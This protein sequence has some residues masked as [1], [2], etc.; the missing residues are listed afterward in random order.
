MQTSLLR[1][2]AIGN[3]VKVKTLLARG[4]NANLASEDDRLTPLMWAA[5]NGHPGAVKSLLDKGADPN[6][7][8]NQG[9]TALMLAAEHGHA[10][11]VKLL[12]EHGADAHARD[13]SGSTALGV[14]V[15]NDHKRIVKLL[16]DAGVVMA[17]WMDWNARPRTRGQVLGPG[18]QPRLPK[19]AS[20]L[21][22]LRTDEPPVEPEKKTSISRPPQP[23]TP[24]PPPPGPAPKIDFSGEAPLGEAK[25]PPSIPPQ[26][27]VTP[28]VPAPLKPL[29]KESLAPSPTLPDDILGIQTHT[30]CCELKHGQ[31]APLTTSRNSQLKTE[32]EAF[33]ANFGYQPA[34]IAAFLIPLL[35]KG[36]VRI[37]AGERIERTEI[38]PAHI[39]S[40]MQAETFYTHLLEL[41]K[42][43]ISPEAEAE[44]VDLAD[45]AGE[46]E[47]DETSNVQALTLNSAALLRAVMEGRTT[48]TKVLLD[49]GADVNTRL[50]DGWTALM[51]AAY[52]GHVDTIKVLIAYDADVNAR[53]GHGWTALMVAVWNGHSEIAKALV[54]N[55][56]DVEARDENQKTVLMW[57]AQKGNQEIVQLLLDRG[58]RV[59]ARN[60]RGLTSLTYALREGHTEVANLLRKAGAV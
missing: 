3:T 10:T 47:K 36:K 15:V 5:M 41:L 40:R 20:Q 57:A 18:G 14:A 50:P 56:A 58:V 30:V 11:T 21:V 33:F 35:T 16:T 22:K 12:L 23:L 28:V 17:T 24:P 29:E 9:R 7:C 49:E 6:I 2:A 4:A 60:N 26:E 27:T 45:F 39:L 42:D 32:L 8:D 51:C 44:K 48:T 53:G 34:L 37:D 52:N 1:A 38:S 54:G 55:G 25:P 31:A 43:K 59:N 13:E 46:E 19:G